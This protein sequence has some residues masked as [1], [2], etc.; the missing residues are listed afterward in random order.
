[1]NRI[2]PAQVTTKASLRLFAIQLLS[3]WVTLLDR[4]RIKL[5]LPQPRGLMRLI[6]GM[7]FHLR[8]E[9]FLQISGGTAFEFPEEKC[10]VGP[11]EMCLVSRGLPHR[12]KIRL[13]KMPFYNL[14]MAY[15]PDLVHYHL[16]HENEE[17]IPAILAS[18]ELPG[19]DG[20]H[21]SDQLKN[22][23]EWHHEGDAVRRLAVKGSLLA[24]LA[25]VL[26]A[27]KQP[28][29]DGHEP[30]KVMQARQ[31]IMQ[32][33][34]DPRLS[35]E[36][37]GQSLRSSPDYLS[38]LFRGATGKPLVAYITEKRVARAKDLLASTPLNISEISRAAGY[39]DPSYFTR[40]F[41]RE[42]GIAPRNYRLRTGLEMAGR[43]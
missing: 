41:R 9:L 17:G 35:A 26:A 32:Y 42:T 37:I 3:Q 23:A 38:R 4:N 31:L 12:E 34:S 21:L 39:D 43:E 22:L 16:A 27:I 18:Q 28:P 11:G 7:P 14:V 10:R 1:M 2:D 36:W 8:P 24:N 20:Q 13:R 25:T 40:V 33:L 15:S 19:L 6:P 5:H 29:S 30:F